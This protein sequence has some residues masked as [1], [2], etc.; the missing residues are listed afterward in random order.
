[1]LFITINFNFKKFISQH[2]ITMSA[3]LSGN[4]CWNKNVF[5]RWEKVAIE[6][7]DWTWT[8]KVFQTVAAAAG[9]DN[10]LLSQTRSSQVPS[11][12]AWRRGTDLQDITHQSVVHITAMHL[13]MIRRVDVLLT[14][15]LTTKLI[16]HLMRLTI[17]V[18]SFLRRS[19]GQYL[20]V[21]HNEQFYSQASA[22]VSIYSQVTLFPPCWVHISS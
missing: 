3:A 7:D 10:N 19:T 11:L 16:V 8:G 9:N 12:P 15:L 17:Q 18:A 6:G 1:M 2:T 4:D 5:S 22:V 20:V 21:S 14:Y 13:L